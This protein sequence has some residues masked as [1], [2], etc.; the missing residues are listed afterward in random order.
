MSE[1]DKVKAAVDSAISQIKT[2]ISAVSENA[3]MVEPP[4]KGWVGSMRAA[5]KKMDDP[6]A[7]LLASLNNAMYEL[8]VC[9]RANETL[10]EIFRHKE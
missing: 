8:T 1:Y 3:P 7:R 4:P 2:A 9:R 10:N 5:V 6:H